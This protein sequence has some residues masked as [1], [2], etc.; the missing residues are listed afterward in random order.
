MKLIEHLEFVIGL[1]ERSASQAEIKGALLGMREEIEGYERTASDHVALAAE[2]AQVDKELSELKAKNLQSE[3]DYLR[4]ELEK[5]NE[6][7]KRRS[8][9]ND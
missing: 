9:H 8:L 2:K 3:D 6:S 1:V 5:S 7:R 4:R